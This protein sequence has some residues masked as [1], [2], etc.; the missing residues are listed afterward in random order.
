MTASAIQTFTSGKTKLIDLFICEGEG[1]FSSAEQRT[2]ELHPAFPR[3]G[4]SHGLLDR[5]EDKRARRAAPLCRFFT[6]LPV[7]ATRDVD[8]G[9]NAVRL[10]LPLLCFKAT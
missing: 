9:P 8:A 2:V 1:F 4:R 10:H 6:E 5:R 7:Q 3:C